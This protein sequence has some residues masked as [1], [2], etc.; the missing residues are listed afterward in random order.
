MA[1]PGVN[2]IP[3]GDQSDQ[4]G[5]AGR[6]DQLGG[7]PPLQ[8]AIRFLSLRLPKFSGPGGIA[9]PALLNGAGA[10]G[11]PGGPESLQELLRQLAGIPQPTDGMQQPPGMSPMAPP[12]G[13]VTTAPPLNY[14]GGSPTPMPRVQLPPPVAPPRPQA[15]AP[16]V[17]PGGQGDRVMLPQPA[18][19]PAMGTG[20]ALPRMKYDDPE[21]LLGMLRPTPYRQGY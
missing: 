20:P 3:T 2:F 8:Q 6:T 14:P 4:P 11:F 15:P 21:Q 7:S 1:F 18:P 17:T 5:G 9:P 10:A 19:S 16:R 13:P 12:D